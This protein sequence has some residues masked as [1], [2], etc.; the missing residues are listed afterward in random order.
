MTKNRKT[1]GAMLPKPLLTFALMRQLLVM[2]PTAA[3]AAACVVACDAACVAACIAATAAAAAAYVAAAGAV[4][5]CAAG[6]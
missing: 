5:F 6:R 4:A 3:C 1:K 2:L